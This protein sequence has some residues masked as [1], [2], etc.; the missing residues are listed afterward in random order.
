MHRNVYRDKNDDAEN[1]L[2]FW[3]KS[4]KFYFDALLEKGLPLTLCWKIL[5]NGQIFKIWQAE[6]TGK[7]IY[8]NKKI[9]VELKIHV[10]Y[11]GVSVK[12]QVITQA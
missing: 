4:A 8:Q 1:L 3:N 9:I 7:E 6:N 11:Q 2:Y 5:D 12:L 10:N